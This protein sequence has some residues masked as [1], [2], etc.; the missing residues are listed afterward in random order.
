MGTGI[1]VLINVILILVTI[2][3]GIF[4]TKAG[5]PY[6]S[7]MLSMHKLFTLAFAIFLTMML[8]QYLKVQSPDSLFTVMLITS[9]V[10]LVVLLVSGGVLSV[11]KLYDTMIVVHRIAT[12]VFVIS[13]GVVF[14][15]LLKSS[16]VG[17]G[18]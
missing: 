2:V 10:A 7:A 17:G 18:S 4:L 9:A 3:I 11:D 14:L 15:I 12:G 13:A 6:S 5:K 1:K 16:S 8:I